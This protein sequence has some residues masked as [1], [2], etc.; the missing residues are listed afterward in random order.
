MT[1]QLFAQLLVN[2]LAIGSVY[3]VIAVGF[4]M[5]VRTTRIL[6]FAHGSFYTL[7]AYMFWVTYFV[8]E[9]HIL[10][11]LFLTVLT[12]VIVA[13]ISYM[14]IFNTIRRRFTPTMPLAW[15]LL[16]SAMS[17]VGLMMIFD[18]GVR[19]AFG[20]ESRGIPSIFPQMLHIGDVTLPLEKLV[21]IIFSIILLLS[22]FAL[23][24]LTKLGKAMRAVSIDAE[25]SSLY[26]VN[27]TRVYL[28]SFICG[29]ALAGLAGA[30]IAPIYAIDID[31][32]S[33]VL[34]IA[35]LTV[36]AGGIGSYKGMLLGGL[37][38]GGVLSFGYFYVGGLAETF[39]FIFVLGLLIFRPL[40][41]F[42]KPRY[43]DR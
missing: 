27:T 8:L 16:L 20:G 4:E 5:I 36:V 15:K 7:G 41:A 32:G 23:V 34:F 11:S 18:A 9:F 26:G 37:I 33:H 6:N 19:I 21:T 31:M 25:A 10:I 3:I 28:T 14:A 24:Y 1:T 22:L 35:M 42:G 17:S 2:A 40:G 13:G 29:V 39:L 30:I 43:D 38:V 12:L